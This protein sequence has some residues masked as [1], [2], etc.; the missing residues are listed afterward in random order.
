M[1]REELFEAFI[2]ECKKRGEICGQGNPNADILIIGKEHYNKVP[3][4]DQEKIKECLQKNYDLCRNKKDRDASRKKDK[5]P[6]WSNYQKLIEAIDTSQR[7]DPNVRDF[8][9]M[10]FTTE[11]N[12][13]FRPEAILDDKTRENI[14]L[15][16]DFFKQSG[17]IRSFNIVVLACGNFITNDKESGFQINETFGVEYDLNG[18]EHKKGYKAGHWFYTHHGDGGKK[19]VIHTR[20]LSNLRDY[21]FITHMANEI[22]KHQDEINQ[23]CEQLNIK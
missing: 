20:Q 2:N 12:T 11:L 10:A 13:A 14:R 18:G 21:S 5:N 22:K 15:R 19:L 4:T 23:L 16:L 3:I 7:H 9:K 17:F 8:E 1:D 6:T